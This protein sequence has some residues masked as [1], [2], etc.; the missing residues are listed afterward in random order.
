M[1]RSSPTPPPLS[2][3]LALQV[4]ILSLEKRFNFS[5]SSL[6]VEANG[7]RDFVSRFHQIEDPEGISRPFKDGGQTCSCPAGG[8]FLGWKVPLQLIP[9]V[10]EEYKREEHFKEQCL[11]LWLMR[12]LSEF[13]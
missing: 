2:P 4:L 6:G 11:E 10:V 7:Y 1:T 13:E 8:H 12:W 9:Q 3:H 5:L